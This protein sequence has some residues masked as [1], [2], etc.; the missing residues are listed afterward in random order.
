MDFSK[1]DRRHTT[2]A[3]EGRLPEKKDKLSNKITKKKKLKVIKNYK[4]YLKFLNTIKND[5]KK[6]SRGSFTLYYKFQM[7]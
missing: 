1:K 4:G 6:N 3:T 2:D 7:T 5:E